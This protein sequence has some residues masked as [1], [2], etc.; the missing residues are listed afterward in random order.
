MRPTHRPRSGERAMRTITAVLLAPVLKLTG[1]RFSKDY[2]WGTT[3]RHRI[4][5]ALVNTCSANLRAD[6][7]L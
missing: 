6:G 3:L 2:R 7:V 1:F 5:F 4:V